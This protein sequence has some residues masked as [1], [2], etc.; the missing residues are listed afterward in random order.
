[1]AMPVKTLDVTCTA[2]GCLC[3]DVTI[4]ADGLIENACP[5][6]AA[7]INSTAQY[8][9]PAP[10]LIAGKPAEL[11]D[12]V[13]V[14]AKMLALARFPLVFGLAGLCIDGQRAA[15]AL[16]DELGA[17]LDTGEL[18][19]SAI[20]MPGVGSFGCT[21]GEVIQRADL[22]V[23]WQCQL[24]NGWWRHGERVLDRIRRDRPIE[25]VTTDAGIEEIWAL[26]A[27]I[28]GRQVELSHNVDHFAERLKKAKYAVIIHH[29]EPRLET[30]I[31]SLARDVNLNTRCRLVDLGSPQN[32]AGQTQVIRWQTGYSRSVGLHRGYPVSFGR[33]FA[34]E[35]VLAR[36]E[37]DAVVLV[38]DALD[39]LSIAARDHLHAI[40]HTHI[41]C[42]QMTSQIDGQITLFVSTPGVN[43]AG[44]VFRADGLTLPLRPAYSSSLP[45]AS[46]VLK[47]LK[48]AIRRTRG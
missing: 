36:R 28:Q 18:E 12:A 10:A 46:L 26:R 44:A 42:G 23:Y 14:A 35:S 17:C 3:D 4:L 1:M 34:A 6:G 31:Q 45:A 32:A 21:W 37:A 24:D 43:A 8:Q 47:C 11:N 2:C 19:D 13:A 29:A 27:A 16:A 39:S 9:P 22:I 41:A 30:A 25:I 7:W 5:H 33:E 48:D 15:V 38:G 40:P 20:Y